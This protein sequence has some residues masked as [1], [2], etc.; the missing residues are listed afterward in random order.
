VRWLPTVGLLGATTAILWAYGVAPGT[1]VRFLVY[2]GLAIALPGT[3][4]WRALHPRGTF[5]I[6]VAAG[7][8]VGYIG[9][10]FVYV[11]GR[12]VGAPLLVLAWPL[13]TVALFA[14]LPRL[15]AAGR[16]ADPGERPPPAWIWSIAAAVGLSVLWSC[17]FYRIYGLTWPYNSAP[18]TDSTFHLALVGE[19]K[20]HMPLTIPW[21]HGEPLY[22]HWFVYPEM[23]ATSWV[24]GIEPQVLL[25]RLSLLPMLA[26]FVVLVAALARKLTGGWW[27]GPVAVFFTLFV[28][29][30][31]PYGWGVA[32]FYTNLAFSN[33]DDGSAL[34]LTVWSGPT[35]TLGALLF[36][37]LALVLVDLLRGDGTP[38][39]WCFFGVL[40]C[41]VM[42]A[43][44]TY[45]PL[46]LA[47]LL[48]VG[49]LTRRRAAFG[50]AGLTL[51][52]VL[53]AQFVLFGGASQ[54]LRW[55]PLATL[56]TSAAGGTTGLTVYH[57]WWRLLVMLAVALGCWAAIWAGAFGLRRRSLTPEVLLML[58]LG[59][60]GLVTT[61]LTGQD[62]DSQRYFLEA[63]RPYLALAAT[64]GLAGML[65]GGRLT[66]RGLLA[67]AG[68][69][70]V[71]MVAIQ[72]VQHATGPVTPTY[73]LLHSYP[74]VALRVVWPYAALSA[75]TAAGF[76]GLRR[77]AGRGALIVALLAGFGFMTTVA[78]Y[79][80]I[81]RDARADG[82]RDA[83]HGPALV[84]WGTLE[85]GRWLRD[86]SSP[87]DLV[88][89]NAHCLFL[90]DS[91][92]NLHFSLAAYSE[93]R[94]LVEGWG[95]TTTAHEKAA[96]EDLWVGDVPY[97]NAT[98]LYDNDIAF[99][100]PDREN[101]ARLRDKYNVKWFFVDESVRNVSPS[102][103]NFAIERY[104]F[105]H[106][107]VY[108]V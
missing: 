28:L 26:A 37:P 5:V 46:L 23:A 86:H 63:G 89:T 32:E 58:A 56:M 82:W 88:A 50:A 69:A 11:L 76:V 87:N 94:M 84:S 79:A 75:L 92:T 71:G 53:F 72:V 42:G 83:I 21:V 98:V 29:A 60:A 93:R 18:D 64:V 15:R 107:V 70:L 20:H 35:Q 39:R 49:G 7:V 12:F 9:E 95:F 25:L 80:R 90:V 108:Q 45:L 97:W 13:G 31:N 33:V 27:S 68:A 85:A 81:V 100:A 40:L 51:A 77:V 24:T 14:A 73:S 47:A 41:G 10:I 3:L 55:A 22:Y 105:G 96:E 44:A 101:V 52:A 34:R 74:A 103:G 99:T 102:L 19:A 17:K 104:R 78:N 38:A 1:S 4:W 91:C 59:L 48:L 62:G 106:C 30:P 43:K 54:G 36:G 16:R 2:L 61:A 57:V 66:R 6:E 67:L 8:A 65:P